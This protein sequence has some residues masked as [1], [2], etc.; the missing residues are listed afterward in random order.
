LTR[1]NTD[2]IVYEMVREIVMRDLGIFLLGMV[3]MDVLWAVKLG[4]PQRMYYRLK[5]RNATVSNDE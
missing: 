2:I 3:F 1:S 5:N 4:I